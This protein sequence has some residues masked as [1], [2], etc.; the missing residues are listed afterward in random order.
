MIND[1]LFNKVNYCFFFLKIATIFILIMTVQAIF[2][3][4]TQ[5]L[6]L[7]KTGIKYRTIADDSHPVIKVDMNK[8]GRQ[9]SEVNEPGYTSWDI[10]D[11]D[12]VGTTIN[13]V[14]ISFRRVGSYGT[15]LTTQWYKAGVSSP[16]YARLVSDGIM[17]ANGNSGAQ[18]RMRITGLPA[19]QHTLLTYHNTFDSPLAFTFS[20]ID[21]YVNGV[22]T[23]AKLQPSN[24]ATKTSDV[25]T[26]Y[27][28][29]TAET[30]K[31]IVVL[32]VADTTSTATQ[33][34]VTLCGF[35]INTTNIAEAARD[36]L[37]A[38]NDEHADADSKNLTLKWSPAPGVTTHQVYF[39]TDSAAIANATITSP[40][41]KGTVTND[42]TF[43]VNNVYCMNKYYWRV[44]EVTSVGLVTMGTVWYFRSRHLAF[45]GAEGYGRFAM[46][47]RGG[48][49]VEVT[50]LNDDGPGSFREAVTN[51]IG[52]RTVVFTVSGRIILNSRLTINSKY[53]TI[54][55]QTAPGKGIC[56][57][58]APLG[59]A[60][61]GICRF[62][63][64]RLGAGITY[65]GMGMAG[66][67]HGILDHSSISWTIDESFSSRNGRNITLQRTLISE[68]LNVAGHQNY[69]AGTAHGYAGSISGDIGS[70]HHN[71]LAHNEGRNWSLAGGLD[72]SG[73]YAGKM[74]IFNMVVY[75]WGGRATD[76]GANQVNF[77]NNYY[78]KGPATTQNTILK[79]QL[80]GA[81]TG[82]QS[83]YYAGNIEQN[84]NG[85]F[86][87]DG[88]SSSCG[89]SYVLSGGQVLDWTVFVDKPFFP[90][91]A[92]IETAKDAYKSVTSDVGCTLPIFDDHDKRIV[93]ETLTGTYTY[94]G[95]VSGKPGLIDNQNDAGGYEDYPAETRPADFDS[96]H[97]G[98]PDWWEILH[99]TNPNSAAGDFS[100]ANA[101]PDGD[102]Y[103]ALEDYLEWMSVPHYNMQPNTSNNIVLTDFTKGYVNPTYS[104]N[105]PGNFNLAFD[106]SKVIVTPNSASLGI[107]YIDI[108]ATDSEGSTFTRRIGIYVSSSASGIKTPSII[109]TF[110]CSPNPT[111][112]MVTLTF[113]SE[114]TASAS[115]VVRDVAGKT[116][117]TKQIDATAGS[118]SLSLNVTQFPVAAY[119]VTLTIADS[120][121]TFKIV[122]E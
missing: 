47:G 106:A 112:D 20:P 76:G 105:Q 30:G 39:G 101:D 11:A 22:L 72:G 44:D 40:L 93:N 88:T 79:A 78:K 59:L 95:S 55:G 98:L 8:T 94:S 36:P 80:E 63:R 16:Y 49:V 119:F 27:F 1:V 56:F 99:G 12:S 62:V 118:N 28:K 42:T 31:D 25:P 50:N 89:N 6:S 67:N 109:K 26:K 74:D 84:T 53:V 96:D 69:P 52:P 13:G 21:I 37:P 113:E 111:K 75:N 65:D 5:G 29:I 108:K 81:G 114:Q 68:A 85:T 10:V 102:G 100:D 97:D 70:F 115:I 66:V 83:Y 19:G 48:K 35:E 91:Y 71:L 122:K 4:E 9:D 23:I 116:V 17:V 86:A 107:N 24:R 2:A 61:E 57:S 121:Q 87:C 82:S 110:K 3:Q 38:T 41:Y 15:S 64:M 14:T 60:S 90:S 77:V 58:A 117:L 45:R 43:V 104:C 120:K 54:A 34:N 51:D 33:K 73:A 18:I 46:G 92:T 32:F 7:N 103:T